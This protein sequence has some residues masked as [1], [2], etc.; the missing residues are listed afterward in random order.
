MA[1]KWHRRWIPVFESR[2]EGTD[3]ASRAKAPQALW[4]LQSASDGVLF[5]EIRHIPCLILLGEP[6]I[7]KTFAVRHEQRQLEATIGEAADKTLWVD[8]SGCSSVES[9]RSELF[10]SEN[11]RNWKAGAHR[12]TMFIDS[13]DQAGIPVGQVVTAIGNEVADA[14]VS[15]L[16]MR[17]VCRDYAW[18]L[19]LADAVEHVWRSYGDTVAKVAVL[20]LAP[21]SVDDIR[22]AAEANRIFV[23]DP[24]AFLSG[25]EAAD[26]LPLAIVPITLE[27]LLKAP[28]Y[29]TRQSNTS[30]TRTARSKSS[31][32]NNDLTSAELDKRF[33][34]ACR[35]AASMVFGRKHAVDVTC[36]CCP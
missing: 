20:Q 12:L 17:L 34:I 26:A 33:E 7:G 36:A 24:E 32:A 23:R 1:Y 4:Q 19:K 2:T 9:V 31:E 13:V 22:L 21:L 14:E 16:Q 18:S 8:L 10:D 30:C 25:L 27:M 15:R 3:V 11:Y 29:L 28:G 5:S 6:G 35:T